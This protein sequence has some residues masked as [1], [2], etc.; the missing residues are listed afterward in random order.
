[1]K[2]K[3]RRLCKFHK[4]GEE[5]VCQIPRENFNHEWATG[6]TRQEAFENLVHELRDFYKDLERSECGTYLER[7]RK[8]LKRF[9]EPGKEEG[10]YYWHQKFLD[11]VIKPAG[12]IEACPTMS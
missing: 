9:F 1:M 4:D 2:K 3:L 11:Y 5:W 10:I 6:K 12:E 7:V 8:T